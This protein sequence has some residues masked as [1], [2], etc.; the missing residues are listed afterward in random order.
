MTSAG[1]RELY[2]RKLH[3]STIKMALTHFLK[4][5]KPVVRQTFCM[6][7]TCLNYNDFSP[8]IFFFLTKSVLEKLPFKEKRQIQLETFSL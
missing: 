7:A 1:G 8:P 3:P 4:E 2:F 6:R 5:I